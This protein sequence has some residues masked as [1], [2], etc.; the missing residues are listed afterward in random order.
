MR[1]GINFGDN[2]Y[3]ATCTAFT[4]VLLLAASREPEIQLTKA[5]VVELFNGMAYSLYRLVQ[6]RWLYN[7]GGDESTKQYLRIKESQVYL[8]EEIDEKLEDPCWCNHS[9]F[10]VDLDNAETGVY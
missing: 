10:Y 6:N 2:D 9:F 4:E 7:H 1:I 5:Q 8:N 3:W